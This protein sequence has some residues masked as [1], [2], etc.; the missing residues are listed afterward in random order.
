M[1]RNIV[2]FSDGTGQAGGLTPDENISNIYKLYRATRCGPDTEIDPRHGATNLL[3][4][5]SGLATRGWHAFRR[6]GPFK[7]SHGRPTWNRQGY[8]CPSGAAAEEG[9]VGVPQ[10]LA[11]SH[12]VAV[13]VI[14]AWL[15]VWTALGT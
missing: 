10:L 12:L 7:G 1:A 15:V 3:R 6:H 13:F 11:E 4:S 5:R 2:V 9:R 14:V 8:P